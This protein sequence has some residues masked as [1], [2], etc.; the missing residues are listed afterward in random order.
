MEI[1]EFNYKRPI[2]LP[3]IKLNIESCDIVAKNRKLKAV[4]TIEAAQDL[5]NWHGIQSSWEELDKHGTR[6]N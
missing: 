4:W 6:A 2:K 1:I 3:E 5:F